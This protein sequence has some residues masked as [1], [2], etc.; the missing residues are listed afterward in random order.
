MHGKKEITID[1]TKQNKIKGEFLPMPQRLT[2]LIHK[3]LLKIEG[4]RTKNLI[5]SEKDINRRFSKKRRGEN[6]PEM[7]INLFKFIC[8]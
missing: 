4:Q 1:K 5:E 8:N 2:S 6:D 3:E 7:Y